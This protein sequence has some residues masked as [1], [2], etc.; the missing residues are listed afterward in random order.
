M[1]LVESIVL[2]GF[3]L[4]ML[5]LLT[6]S[7]LKERLSL[8]S[9]NSIKILFYIIMVGICSYYIP[10]QVI[11]FTVSTVVACIMLLIIYKKSVSNTVFLYIISMVIV[12]CAQ[13][14]VMLFF[15]I[16][17]GDILNNFSYGL[18]SQACTIIII[19]IVKRCIPIY[20][21]YN[22]VIEKNKIVYYLLFNSFTVLIFIVIYWYIN[23]DGM[24]GNLISILVLSMIIVFI[25]FV[26]VKNG[27]K[28][29]FKEQELKIYKT[30]LPV[31]E[32]LMDDIRARQH[33]FDNHIQALK[34][35]QKIDADNRKDDIDELIG[36]Y[37]DNI[38]E[39]NKW[40][41]LIKLNNKMLAGFLYSKVIQAAREQ[42]KIEIILET[43]FIDTKMED[44]ELIEMAGILINN[45]FEAVGTETKQEV[46]VRIS[47][48]KDM[49]VF[50]VRNSHP[51][52]NDEII[53]KMFKKGF[54]TKANSSRGYGL[55]NINCLARK[56]DGNIEIYN[57]TN[58]DNYVVISVYYK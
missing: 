32:Q 7:L 10:N 1:N 58:E 19:A 50:E 51:Y 28:N 52:L 35:M 48:E 12:Y 14:I 17:E 55:F 39:K 24:V 31:I 4:L 15:R 45:A 54:S 25:N 13:I 16:V 40:N 43:Y 44:F 57:D 53:Q 49:N 42:I 29:Q 30:Y 21:I 56:Y 36:K 6:C 3:D 26:I 47:K 11:G 23:I 38:M 41:Y 18:I 2:S 37:C 5:N 33:E 9:I 27:L 46:V 34:M 8:R 22:Y 20:V